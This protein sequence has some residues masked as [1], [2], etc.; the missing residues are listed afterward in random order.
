[1]STREVKR[2]P[3]L[4][5]QR[6]V[7]DPMRRIQR[8]VHDLMVRNVAGHGYAGVGVSHLNVFAHVPRDTG[9]RMSEL[10]A[11]LQV[12]PGAVS[13]VVGQL[14]RMGLV[15]RVPDPD[16]GRGVIV[17]PTD[18]AEAGYEAGRR[19]LSAL[20]REWSDLVGR[21]RWATFERVLWEIA[22]YEER[23]GDAQ[24]F[25]SVTA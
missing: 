5:R 24:S 2:D 12:T 16:D 4:W 1:M 20:Q 11:W 25:A 17:R 13:Q 18:A 3:V 6:F 7:L 10:A 21:R 15:E 22:E 8:S 14:E 9:M 19:L 23:R